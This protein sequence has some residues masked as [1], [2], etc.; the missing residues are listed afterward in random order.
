M[1]D[2]KL[3]L[4][5][6]IQRTYMKAIRCGR[7]LFP[8]LNCKSSFNVKNKILLYRFCIRPIMMYGCQMWPTKCARTHLKKLQII[9]NKNLKIIYNLHRRYP[10]I[11]LHREYKGGT[12]F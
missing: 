4:K 9:Q 8:L 3:T 12:C 7:A 10:T 5:Q 6:H 2:K 1:L 11:Q